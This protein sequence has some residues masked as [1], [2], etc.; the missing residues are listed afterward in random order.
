MN[1]FKKLLSVF[2]SPTKVFSESV[3]SHVETSVSED[4]AILTLHVKATRSIIAEIEK[5]LRAQAYHMLATSSAMPLIQ[6]KVED[7]DQQES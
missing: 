5:P 1:L 3:H 2:Q 6:Q 4:V 7:S